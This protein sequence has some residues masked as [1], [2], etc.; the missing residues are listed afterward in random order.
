MLTGESLPVEK[1]AEPVPSGA[2]IHER[3]SMLFKGCAISRGT[4]EAV[5]TATGMAT[6]LGHITKLVEEAEPDR[7]PLERQLERLSRN[8]IWLTLVVT[9]AVALTGI[10]SGRDLL[11]MIDGK[12]MATLSYKTPWVFDLRARLRAQQSSLLMRLESCLF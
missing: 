7:S 12:S 11:T 8:L 1:S 10:W 6:E 5:V 2:P 9:S 4:G 3:A